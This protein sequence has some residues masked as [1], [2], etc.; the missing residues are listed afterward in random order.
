MSHDGA[1]ETESEAESESETEAESEAESEAGADGDGG[2]AA[3]CVPT[4]PGRL[5]ARTSTR[6]SM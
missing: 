3:G 2:I 5:G 1:A 6:K 4:E